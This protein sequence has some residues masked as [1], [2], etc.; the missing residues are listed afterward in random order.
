MK[1][2]ELLAQ[3]RKHMW[4][5]WQLSSEELGS[6]AAETLLNLGMLVPEGGAQELEQWRATFGPDALPGA[7]SRLAR[8]EQRRA[9]LEAVLA[10]HRKDDQAEIERLRARVAELEA[11][12]ADH[13]QSPLAWAEKLDAKSLDNF[14]IALSSA[15]ECEPMADA[16]AQIHKL[17]SSYRE[18]RPE[19][20]GITR[21]IAPTQAL[22]E[23]APHAYKSRPLPPGTVKCGCGHPGSEHHHAST[24]CYAHLPREL[25]Q[26]VRICPCEAFVPVEAPHDSPLHHDYRVGRDLPETGGAR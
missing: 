3:A 10:T 8:A 15:T 21:R 26:P 2:E 18:A 12:L 23:R 11:R 13:E 19:A 14:L 1:R 7:L 6:Q 22:R 4:A 20:D 9:E 17:I 16:I 24:A 5:A 25:G